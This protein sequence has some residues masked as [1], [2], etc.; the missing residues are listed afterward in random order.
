MKC[1]RCKQLLEYTCNK[2]CDKCVYCIGYQL[3]CETILDTLVPIARGII[4]VIN[5]G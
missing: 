1:I 4:E 5:V 2:T 3:V